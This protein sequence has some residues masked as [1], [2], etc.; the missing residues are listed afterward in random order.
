MRARWGQLVRKVLLV[1]R[2]HDQNVYKSFRNFPHLDVRAA[3]DLCAYD[4][5]SARVVLAEQGAL[6]LVAERVGAGAAAEAG[7]AQ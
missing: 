2:G 1:T 4:V 6:D 3:V 5:V 7:G